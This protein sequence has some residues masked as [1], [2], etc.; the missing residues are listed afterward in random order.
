VS[1]VLAGVVLLSSAASLSGV[2]S[3]QSPKAD[4]P[5]KQD[6]DVGRLQE[7]LDRYP[8]A[9]Y[10][11][12]EQSNSPEK[13]KRTKRNKRYDGKG[14]VARHPYNNTS[15][16]SVNDDRFQALPPLPT[17]ESDVIL[18][19]DVLSSEAHISNDRLGVYSE[20]NVQV[21]KVL[22]GS[23]PTLSQTNLI[24]VSRF[25]GVVRYPS[26]HTEVYSIVMQNMPALGKRYLFFLKA[27]DDSDDFQIITGYEIGSAQV[28]PL[29]SNPTFDAFKG[30][31]PTEFLDTVR[32]AITNN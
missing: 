18:I 25:G 26:G 28:L 29:D 16:V 5:Q 14:L 4:R 21:D 20:F 31:N 23:V 19:A 32:K 15:G 11:T 12:Q 24:S 6:V 30:K 17:S 9:D 7:L 27:T 13:A 3:S 22:K 1:V 10:E 2:Q 8:T